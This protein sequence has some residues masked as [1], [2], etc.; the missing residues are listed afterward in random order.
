MHQAVHPRPSSPAGRCA[1]RRD[2]AQA[3][4]RRQP[5][6]LPRGDHGAGDHRGGRRPARRGYLCRLPV[7]GS[8]GRRDRVPDPAGGADQRVDTAGPARPD[9]PAP[10]AGN[11]P[12]A[13]GGR[14]APPGADRC[15]AGALAEMR[16]VAPRSTASARAI[17]RCTSPSMSHSTTTCST[18][19]CASSGR[20]ATSPSASTR[21]PRRR[22][23][24]PARAHRR[25]D[26]RDA[27]PPPPAPRAGPP[28]H[29]VH[30]PDGR[31]PGRTLI[32][33]TMPARARRN[34][35][36]REPTRSR[37]RDVEGRTRLASCGQGSS[38]AAGGPVGR[39]G[40]TVV[41]GCAPAVDRHPTPRWGS[42]AQRNVQRRRS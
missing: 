20:S 31:S 37:R 42:A 11:G 36:A 9:R 23:S 38:R 41:R 15:H 14:R 28:R 17:S 16:E 32:P 29:W 8:A 7:A 30:H 21:P 6:H 25:G 34:R 12:D 33:V 4:D 26:R 35:S 13:P 10:D 5:S 24:S 2:G 18:S 3:R 27:M 22:C 19:S 1:A 39:G 40:G